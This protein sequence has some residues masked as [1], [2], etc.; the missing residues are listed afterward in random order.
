M[1]QQSM[2]TGLPQLEIRGDTIC[3]RA[4]PK[5]LT[6]KPSLSNCVLTKSYFPSSSATQDKKIILWG[7]SNGHRLP[8]T[9]NGLVVNHISSGGQDC[10]KEFVSEVTIR[11]HSLSGPTLNNLMSSQLDLNY[12]VGFGSPKQHNIHSCNQRTP[13]TTARH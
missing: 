2:F 5:H 8:P 3:A 4:T 9:A 13:I 11:P 7:L 1:M 12:N 10:I 6:R